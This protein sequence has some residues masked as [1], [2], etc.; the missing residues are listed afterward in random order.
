MKGESYDC[1]TGEYQFTV[2]VLDQSSLHGKYYFFEAKN[3]AQRLDAL[4]QPGD[5]VLMHLPRE[6]GK[7]FSI[8]LDNILKVNNVE[9]STYR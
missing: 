2:Y 9:V 6:N 8:T 7:Q 1:K 4:L 5:R 3:D